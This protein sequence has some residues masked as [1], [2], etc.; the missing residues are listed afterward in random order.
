[1]KLNLVTKTLSV[2][3]TRRQSS[4][5]HPGIDHLLFN[6]DRL[7]L[8]TTW[9]VL[10]AITLL[11]SCSRSAEHGFRSSEEAIKAYAD[12][13]SDGKKYGKHHHRPT[14]GIDTAMVCAG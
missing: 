13:F 12:F 5:L 9:V 8:Y 10:L 1:M 4:C 7:L 2:R 6:G 11:A 3:Q 14:R